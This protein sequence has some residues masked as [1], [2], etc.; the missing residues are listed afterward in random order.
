MK[1]NIAI[2]ILVVAVLAG[3]IWFDRARP[4][5]NE[6][7][8]QANQNTTPK[9]MDNNLKIEDITVGTGAEAKKGDT[10]AVNYIGTLENGSKFDSSYDRNQPFVFLLGGGQVITGWDQGIVGMRVGGKRKLT[11]PPEMGYGAGGYPPVIPP[12]A[13]LIFT[14]ELV[15]V[16]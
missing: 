14:V 3:A 1:R 12:S 7:A 2:A 8:A 16:K 6:Q 15:A 9:Q 11:I 13:T 10:V 4:V 5:R